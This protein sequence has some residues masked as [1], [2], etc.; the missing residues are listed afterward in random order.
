MKGSK[1]STLCYVLHELR[2]A[3]SFASMLPVG[4]HN[5][6]HSCAVG[7]LVHARVHTLIE[8]LCELVFLSHLP[9]PLHVIFLLVRQNFHFLSSPPFLASFPYEQWLP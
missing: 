5:Q 2:P 4:S 9:V 7:H 8:R 1:L 6:S 3:A